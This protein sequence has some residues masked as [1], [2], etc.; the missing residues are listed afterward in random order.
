LAIERTND[1]SH[2]DEFYGLEVMFNQSFRGKGSGEVEHKF[3]KMWAESV[4]SESSGS[5]GCKL[6][7]FPAFQEKDK[8]NISFL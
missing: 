8:L 3:W 2:K 7:L 1:I 6:H 4:L 5:P